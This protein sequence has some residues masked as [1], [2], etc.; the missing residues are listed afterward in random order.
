[1]SKDKKAIKTTKS[2]ITAAPKSNIIGQQPADQL[3][4]FH[5]V[6]SLTKIPS[7]AERKWHAACVDERLKEMGRHGSEAWL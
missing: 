5:L 3:P 4:W 1:M 6:T 7:D 2:G